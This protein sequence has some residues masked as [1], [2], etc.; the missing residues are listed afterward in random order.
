M[1]IKTIHLKIVTDTGMEMYSSWV[2]PQFRRPLPK[3]SRFKPMER[4]PIKW[5]SKT[6]RFL[7]RG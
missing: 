5:I 4:D 1:K 7:Q 6:V 2:G 3:K